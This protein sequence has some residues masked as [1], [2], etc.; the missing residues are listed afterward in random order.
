MLF[1]CLLTFLNCSNPK[2]IDTS[3]WVETHGEIRGNYHNKY[4][5]YDVNGVSYKKY[6]KR[7]YYGA[8][9]NY[10]KYKVI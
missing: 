6:F 2:D 4:I 9:T 8:L 1:M 10:E 7:K 3:A 5:Y